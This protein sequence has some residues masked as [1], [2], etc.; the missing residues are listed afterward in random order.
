MRFFSFFPAL[1]VLPFKCAISSQ[2]SPV[3]EVTL[4]RVGNTRIKGVVK[5]AGREDISFV[6]LN[7][8]GDSAP[9]KKVSIFRENEE[10][11]FEGVIIRFRAEGLTNESVTSLAAGGT[12]EDEFDLASTSDLTAGGPILVHSEGSVPVVTNGSVTGY[13]AYQSN[14]LQFE[15]DAVEAARVSRALPSNSQRRDFRCNSQTKDILTRA[16]STASRLASKAVESA[17]SSDDIRFKQFFHATDRQQ[18]TIVSNQFRAVAKEASSGGLV[19]YHCSDPYGICGPDWVAYT[20]GYLTEIVT[21]DRF[22]S[23]YPLLTQECD[24]VD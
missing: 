12:L 16:I 10:V 23:Q 9:V 8:F 7:F 3:L 18:R 14:T 2:L 13:V 6:H 21:C 24:S 22:Y 20:R 15:V 1:F 19:T 5:N 11:D 17:E 4:S